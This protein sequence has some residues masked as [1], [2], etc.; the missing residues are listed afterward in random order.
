MELADSLLAAGPFPSRKHGS[1][2]EESSL[3]NPTEDQP[4]RERPRILYRE[5]SEATGAGFVESS[6]VGAGRYG[7][8]HRREGSR[9]GPK[10]GGEVS[11]SFKRECEVLRRNAAQ[12][13]PRQ[14]D[15]HLQ[16]GQ[17]PSINAR[18]CC[19]SCGHT[20]GSL[21]ARGPHLYPAV[22]HTAAKSPAR[23]PPPDGLRLAHEHQYGLGGHPS[24]HGDVVILEQITGK[25]PADVIF[26]EGRLTLHDWHSPAQRLNMVDI[27]HEITLLKEDL[28]ARGTAGGGAADGGRSFSTTKDSLF[29]N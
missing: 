16:H 3:G 24:A 25:R 29:S 26:R 18:S 8:A 11:G 21:V 22:R 6:L 9:P 2:G 23:A 12:E 15:H 10:G 27:C 1:S 5:L 20:Y 14:G 28:N 17:Q 13:R 19:R 4:E 7:R